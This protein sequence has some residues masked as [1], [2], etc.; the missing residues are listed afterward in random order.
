MIHRTYLNALLEC[1]KASRQR[2]YKTALAGVQVQLS[3]AFKL[4]DSPITAVWHLKYNSERSLSD[5]A[6]NCY[7]GKFMRQSPINIVRHRFAVRGTL[8]NAWYQKSIKRKQSFEENANTCIFFIDIEYS[9]PKFHE[10]W[11]FQK[12][13][14]FLKDF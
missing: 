11:D 14:I 8:N 4:N 6:A 13:R 3:N 9:G 1:M 5:A 10:K 7:L 2:T 12:F